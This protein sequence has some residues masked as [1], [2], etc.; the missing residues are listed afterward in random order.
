MFGSGYDFKGI[1]NKIKEEVKGGKESQKREPG[2]AE[3]GS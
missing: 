2:E 3:V 1:I